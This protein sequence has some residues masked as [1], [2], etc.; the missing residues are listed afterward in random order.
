MSIVESLSLSL[1]EGLLGEAELSWPTWQ[2]R[3]PAL[4]GLE[5][6][7]DRTELLTALSRQRADDVLRCVARLAAVDGD[8]STAAAGLLC[9]I[10]LPGVSAMAGRLQKGRRWPELDHLVGSALWERARTVNWRTGWKIAANLIWN[11]E[12]DVRSQFRPARLELVLCG[13]ERDLPDIEVEEPQPDPADELTDALAV[14]QRAGSVTSLDRHLLDLVLAE[15]RANPTRVS[16][17]GVMAVETSVAVG[18]AVGR[19]GR[20]VRARISRVVRA[21]RDA[22]LDVA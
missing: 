16:T 13:D 3:Y 11:V 9:W 15:L 1:G 2:R 12:S 10:V 5:F 21:I 7:A 4:A 6:P 19:S 17:S 18:R 20:A 22:N 8:N 14:A